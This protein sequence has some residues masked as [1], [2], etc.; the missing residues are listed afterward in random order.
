MPITVYRINPYHSTKK[1]KG[2][3]CSAPEQKEAMLQERLTN[4]LCSH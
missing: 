1:K 2:G 3:H 4:H